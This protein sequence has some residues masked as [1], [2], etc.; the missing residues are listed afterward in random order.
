MLPPLSARFSISKPKSSPECVGLHQPI[1][2]ILTNEK[3]TFGPDCSGL[4][5]TLKGVF[6]NLVFG[7]VPV[8]N[9]DDVFRQEYILRVPNPATMPVCCH[10][11]VAPLQN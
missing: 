10:L 11:S 2:A 6:I 8:G 4:G 7:Q 5:K 3:V 1:L 9:H